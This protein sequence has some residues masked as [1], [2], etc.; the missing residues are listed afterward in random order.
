MN[1]CSAAPY[2]AGMLRTAGGVLMLTVLAC[3]GE[4]VPR[5]LAPPPTTGAPGQPAVPGVFDFGCERPE[6]GEAKTLRRLSKTE[7]KAHLLNIF[8]GLGGAPLEAA[9]DAKLAGLP[10]DVGTAILFPEEALKMSEGHIQALLTFAESLSDVLERAGSAGLDTLSDGRCVNPVTALAGCAEGLAKRL[11]LRTFRRPLTVSEREDLSAHL[12]SIGATTASE[13]VTAA[14]TYLVL[15]PPSLM[16]LEDQGVVQ[17]EG[18]AMAIT[19]YESMNR[20]YFGLLGV[21]PPVR[22]LE[23][24]GATGW[25]DASARSEVDTVLASQAFEARLLGFFETVLGFGTDVDLRPLP[26][27]MTTGLDISNV[28]QEAYAELRAFLRETIFTQRGTMKDL[29]ESTQVFAAGPNLEKIY[30]LT[31]GPSPRTLDSSRY[32]GLLSRVSMNLHVES[33]TKPIARGVRVKRQLFCEHI[34]PPP[35]LDPL[36]G[37]GIVIDDPSKYSG[38]FLTDNTTRS[39]GCQGCH[40]SINSIGFALDFYDSLGRY[41]SLETRYTEDGSIANVFPLT[42]DIGI[43]VLGGRPKKVGGAGALVGE[44]VDSELASACLVSQWRS[45]TAQSDRFQSLSCL[46]KELHRS[47]ARGGDGVLEMIRK[48]ALAELGAVKPLETAP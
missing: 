23:A 39:A 3:T 48:S 42:E 21:P 27:A 45:F 10:A 37:G 40:S 8:S 22:V 26:G 13:V 47:T 14:L 19:P 5:V 25:S 46:K 7:F 24:I 11:G 38:R 33:R 30:G 15:L 41:R 35:D 44:I 4:F 29:L 28:P 2:D 17:Q 1:S 12:K 34:E 6:R 20:V 43:H 9:L 31:P 16:H 36:S 18:A 32:S